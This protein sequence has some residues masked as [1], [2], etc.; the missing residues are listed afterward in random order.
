MLRCWDVDI[1]RYWYWDIKISGYW[2]IELLRQR[3]IKQ[4]GAELC[5]AQA[6]DSFPADAE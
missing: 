1:F 2:N 6:P 3:D 5:Q 4:A